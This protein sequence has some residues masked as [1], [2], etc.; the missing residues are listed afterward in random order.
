MVYATKSERIQS[1]VNQGNITQFN[2]SKVLEDAGAIQFRSEPA[3]TQNRAEAGEN[4]VSQQLILPKSFH[5]MAHFQ[6]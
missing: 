6:H 2:Q 1:W 4:L 3:W 5:R